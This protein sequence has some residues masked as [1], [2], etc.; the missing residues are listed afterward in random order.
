MS[1]PA[2]NSGSA[3]SYDVPQERI[4]SIEHPCIVKNFNNGFQ[5]LGGEHQLKHVSDV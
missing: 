3:P 4:V 2:T 1:A 5:S